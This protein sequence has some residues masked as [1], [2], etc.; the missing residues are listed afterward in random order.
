VIQE[1]DPAKKVITNG[2][3]VLQRDA[4]GRDAWKAVAAWGRY[5]DGHWWFFDVRIL[6]LTSD[7]PKLVD[8][9]RQR[10]MNE[11]TETPKQ[12]GAELKE[13][14]QMT[15]KELKN[16][17]TLHQTLPEDKRA[18]F[19]VNLHQRFAQ[20]WMCL[21]MVLLAVSLGARVGRKGPLVCVASSLALF[22]VY[23]FTYQTCSE[24]GNS[25]YISPFIAAWAPNWMFGLLG[26][27]GYTSLR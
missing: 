14:E 6:D 23:W 1:F 13:P 10:I 12:L 26:L 4:Q 15:V 11:L 16:Y 19:Q 8:S 25:T 20:P 27:A 17:L 22:F 18:K 21:V 9:G 2:V 3:E 5:L 24:L 7:T